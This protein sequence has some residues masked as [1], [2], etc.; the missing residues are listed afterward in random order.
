MISALNVT[1]ITDA[2]QEKFGV[3]AIAEK[4][5]DEGRAESIK[6]VIN[7]VLDGNKLA[8]MVT[9]FPYRYT[10]ARSGKGVKLTFKG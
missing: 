7:G 2:F 9:P 10:L 4:K 6:G 8:E 5:D 1:K 3:K